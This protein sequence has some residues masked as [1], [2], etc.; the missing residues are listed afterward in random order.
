MITEKATQLLEKYNL[1]YK[2]SG[3]KITP[4]LRELAVEI[5]EELMENCDI[6][7]DE[8]KLLDGVLVTTDIF[9]YVSASY[10]KQR[11]NNK[12][13]KNTNTKEI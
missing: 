2:L 12:S 7:R 11:E 6:T 9:Y 5:T 4:E 8:S 10:R 1:L 3:R 13:V